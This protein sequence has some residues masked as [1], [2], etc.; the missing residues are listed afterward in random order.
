M[1][2]LKRSL[3]FVSEILKYFLSGLLSADTTALYTMFVVKRLLSSGHSALFLQLYLWLL[4]VRWI[5]LR[6]WEAMTDSTFLQQLYFNFIGFLFKIFEHFMRFR[7]VAVDSLEEL[8][9]NICFHN[10]WKWRIELYYF[11][12]TYYN[13]IPKS[14]CKR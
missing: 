10:F 13:Q 2:F 6:L 8:L 14:I 11:Q 4:E 9:A 12:I 1:C 7:Q 5:I 3:N